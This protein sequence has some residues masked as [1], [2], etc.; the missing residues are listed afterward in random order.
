MVLLLVV[1]LLMFSASLGLVSLGHPAWVAIPALVAGA[2][3][4]VGVR[5]LDRHARGRLTL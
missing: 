4:F 5:A 1:V 2:A 3:T